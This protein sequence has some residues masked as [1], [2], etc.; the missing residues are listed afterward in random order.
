MVLPA[1]TPHLKSQTTFLI[2][3]EDQGCWQEKLQESEAE[4]C[5]HQPLDVYLGGRK[6]RMDAITRAWPRC[7]GLFWWAWSP[8]ICSLPYFASRVFV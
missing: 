4:E 5:Q 1:G 2:G 8:S 7:R 6:D 3:D